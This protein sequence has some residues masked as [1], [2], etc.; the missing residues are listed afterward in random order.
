MKS[1]PIAS[2]PMQPTLR[3]KCG[4]PPQFS[5]RAKVKSSLFSTVFVRYGGVYF[6]LAIACFTILFGTI[7]AISMAQDTRKKSISAQL[8]DLSPAAGQAPLKQPTAHIDLTHD[9]H[10]LVGDIAVLN[11]TDALQPY[12]DIPVLTEQESTQLL[13]ILQRE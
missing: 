7:Y 8:S 3:P 6:I 12:Q 4:R 1:S 10:S 11:Y 2:N 13:T 5:S 9:G